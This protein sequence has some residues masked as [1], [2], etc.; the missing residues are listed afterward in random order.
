MP[1]KP[2]PVPIPT[3][4]N[5][6]N[7]EP[8]SHYL[9]RL[10]SRSV[11]ARPRG[12]ISTLFWLAVVATLLVSGPTT[13]AALAELVRSGTTNPLYYFAPIG[14]ALL[15]GLYLMVL[16]LLRHMALAY[17]DAVDSLLESNRKKK[18]GG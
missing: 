17:F 7:N 12:I 5:V 2:Q 1:N 14:L 18:E 13:Y 15:L 8:P 10:R 9:E 6:S 4:V 3:T 16:V 11:Y